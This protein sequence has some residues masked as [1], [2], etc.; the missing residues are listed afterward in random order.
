MV[1]LVAFASIAFV[2]GD[3]DWIIASPERRY[4]GNVGLVP[5]PRIGRSA[6]EEAPMMEEGAVEEEA[7]EEK[8]KRGQVAFPAIR[9]G[10]RSSLTAFP[11]IRFGKRAAADEKMSMKEYTKFLNRLRTQKR[12]VFARVG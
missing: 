6:P 7:S 11:A 1:V 4:G 3:D 10:K 9:F 5:F 2:Y 12:S 8:V